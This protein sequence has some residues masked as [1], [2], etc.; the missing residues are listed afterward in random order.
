MY[1]LATT[2]FNTDTWRQNNEWR[3]R[4]E[5]KGCVY[6]TPVR[7][8]D[9]YTP[10]AY[11]FVLEM[12]NDK[13]KIKG[14]GLIKNN[15]HI[16]KYHKIYEDRNYNRY[17]YKSSQRVDRKN[18]DREQKKTIRILDILLF[19]GSRHLKR[20]QGIIVVPEW[21]SENK[22][23]LFIPFFKKLFNIE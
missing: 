3:E 10:G 14:I 22:H 21:I 19:K 18:L 4:K 16:G 1:Y 11:M 2:R 12:H 23:I 9:K 6:G 13:N 8:A 5:W 15:N 7:I 17:I 20:G